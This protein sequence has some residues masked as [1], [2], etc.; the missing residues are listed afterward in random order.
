MPPTKRAARNN[1]EGA[2]RRSPWIQETPEAHHEHTPTR[3]RT[4]ACDA[5][6]G[7]SPPLESRQLP[8]PQRLSAHAGRHRLRLVAPGP[9]GARYLQ[10][11][12][13]LVGAA[14][15]AARGQLPGDVI[16]HH[17]GRRPPLRYLGHP[18]GPGRRAC[19]RRLGHT[20]RALDLLH[21][22]TPSAVDYPGVAHRQPCH[23]S[24]GAIAAAG[25]AALFQALAHLEL[26]A[27]LRQ[28]R[29]PALQLHL[30]HPR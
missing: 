4:R 29:H 9:R 15:L 27:H 12:P 24:P 13:A 10:P 8:A 22:R 26:R 6:P 25:A 7:A 17:G 28:L 19:H 30:A 23:R 2:S 16:P 14:G 5:S 20:D 1:R 11:P 18:R 21:A 3:S